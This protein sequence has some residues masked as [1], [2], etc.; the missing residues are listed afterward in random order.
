[1]TPWGTLMFV[2]F[3]GRTLVLS[4]GKCRELQISGQPVY[5]QLWVVERG[6][7]EALVAE[8]GAYHAKI[9]CPISRAPTS[10]IKCEL[11]LKGID[12]FQKGKTVEIGISRAN[13]PDAVFTHEDGCMR[14]V[15][16]I[17]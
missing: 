14:V 2:E 8:T 12:N 15:E 7:S 16:Q 10:A 9:V 13:L 5:R 6:N 11:G 3:L 1:M 17:A 4:L